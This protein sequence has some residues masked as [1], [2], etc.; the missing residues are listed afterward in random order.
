MT[1]SGTACDTHAA[2]EAA[3]I[4]IL[5]PPL[6]R[7]AQAQ[8]ADSG[9]ESAARREKRW[10]VLPRVMRWLGGITLLVSAFSFL[11]SGYVGAP[12]LVGYFGFLG[13]TLLLSMAGAFCVVRWQDDKGART[14]LAVAT[15]FLPAHFARLGGFVFAWFHGEAEFAAH[16]ALLQLPCIPGWPLAATLAGAGA[17]LAAVAFAGFSAMARGQAARLTLCYL[18]A[19]AALLLPARDPGSVVALC[20]VLLAG[21]LLADCRWFARPAALKTWDGHAVRSML[22]VPLGVLVIRNLMLHGPSQAI[23]SFLLA[24]LA[25]I[26]FFG[27]PRFT[28]VTALKRAWQNLA[29]APALLAWMLCAQLLF[30]ESWPAFREQVLVAGVYP[31][32]ILVVGLSFFVAGSGRAH[33][34]IGAA[35]AVGALIGQLLTDGGAV[36]SLL[37]IAT[38]IVVVLGAFVME[39]KGLFWVGITGLAVGLG[40]HLHYAVQLCQT[41]LWLALALIGMVVVG[42]SSYVERNGRQGFARFARFRQRFRT[43]R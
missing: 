25:G 34:T 16:L 26:L 15:A 1:H 7:A 43:W 29:L 3:H 42:L 9:A 35:I 37:A 10:A 31:F 2:N 11:V 17:L 5:P 14:F 18:L 20:L 28:R 38:A 24:V 40:Y 8:P 36:T 13:F 21:I 33:R 19:N 6:P 32:A 12:A 22:H 4:P 39:E 27:L 23:H 30:A 41:N